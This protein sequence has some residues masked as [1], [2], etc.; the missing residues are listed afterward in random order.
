MAAMNYEE[1]AQVNYNA[2]V[3]YEE[4]AQQTYVIR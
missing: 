3:S 1:D 4:G 2:Q